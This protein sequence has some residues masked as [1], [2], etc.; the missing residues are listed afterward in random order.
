MFMKKFV[1]AALACVTLTANAAVI[2]IAAL[3]PE[4]TNWAKTMK[5]F[6]KEV[7]KAT[8]GKVKVKIYYGGV[9]GD[10]PDV[11][12]KIRVGQLHGGVFTGK[13]LGD[14]AG[15][16]RAIELPF[17]FLHDE[18]KAMK[19]L[20]GMTP[21]FNKK[22]EASGFVNLGFYGIGQ[23]YVVSTK[24]VSSIPQM[25]G[26]KIWSWEGDR[27]V[28]A[29]IS[30]LKLVSV[31]LALPDVLSSLS[32]NIIDA[33]YAPP[34]GILA[35]QWQSQIKYLINFPTAYSI[36]A[37]LISKKG[38][39]K[40]PAKHHA[41]VKEIAKKYVDQAN[42]YS[43]KDNAQGLETL[44]SLGVEFID[45]DDKDIAKAEE[46]RAKVLDKLKGK[47]ISEKAIKMLESYR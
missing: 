33:A 25:Q 30:S 26:V 32:T 44:K 45:F 24:K 39:K 19:A 4:G 37:L 36:G 21:Y 22:I 46:I 11:L 43:V 18:K 31:P 8:D 35:L 9:A 7:K 28:E 14:I 16:I 2:K 47:V 12:R 41:K 38:W 20:K 29:M 5:D 1:L 40:I 42:E 17:N 27:V 3:A 6:S 23:V 10:E 13:T 34:L 15:D